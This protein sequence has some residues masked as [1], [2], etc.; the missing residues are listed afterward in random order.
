[1]CGWYVCT[2]DKGREL[3]L[4]LPVGLLDTGEL[5]IEG[6]LAA[7]SASVGEAGVGV[8]DNGWRKSAS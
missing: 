8:A 7:C 4:C 1:M 2:I 5:L 6:G 3:L